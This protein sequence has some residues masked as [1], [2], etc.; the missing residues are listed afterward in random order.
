MKGGF[1]IGV[2]LNLAPNAL[3]NFDTLGTQSFIQKATITNENGEE[4][5]VPVISGNMIRHYIYENFVKDRLDSNPEKLFLSKEALKFDGN[6]Y[7]SDT[8]EYHVTIDKTEQIKVNSKEIKT[9]YEL[10]SK[11]WD[12]DIFGFMITT[13]KNT[14]SH[15]SPLFVT[16]FVGEYISDM[17]INRVQ[18]S[19]S[20]AKSSNEANESSMIALEKEVGSGWYVGGVRTEIGRIGLVEGDI[21]INKLIEQTVEEKLRHLIR[22]IHRTIVNADFGANRARMD[23]LVLD[24]KIVVVAVK[25][26]NILPPYFTSKEEANEWVTEMSEF[27]TDAEFVVFDRI[28]DLLKFYEL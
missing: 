15:K 20:V 9:L 12:A 24:K 25:N 13:R 3:N 22:A 28:T 14:V 8:I 4:I 10:F 19:P 21:K 17:V 7:P 26:A 27:Y 16:N 6:R 2:K 11:V 5:T 18:Q 23:A 1:S